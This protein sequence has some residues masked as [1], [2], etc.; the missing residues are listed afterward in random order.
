MYGIAQKI[1]ANPAKYSLQQLTDGV[2]SGVIP[3]YI[4]IP[5]IQE[6]IQ[7]EKEAQAM[8]M[9]QNQPPIAEQVL[10]ESSGIDKLPSGLPQSYAGGGIIAFANGGMFDEEDNED[11]DGDYEKEMSRAME[12]I[13]SLR[14]RVSNL[15][16]AQDAFNLEG[17]IEALMPALMATESKEGVSVKRGNEPSKSIERQSSSISQPSDLEKLIAL[18]QQKESGGRRNDREGNVL[19]SPKGAMGEMQ[20]MP[21]TAR[22]PG[23]GIT[24]A[25]AGDLDDLA[26]VGK[27]YFAK[28][29]QRYG[30][31]K[32]AAVAYNWGPGNTDKW[33]MAGADPSRLPD[34]T[35]NYIK[36]FD[37]G[38]IVGLAGGDLIIPPADDLEKQKDMLRRMR[39]IESARAAFNTLPAAEAATTAAAEAPKA[40]SGI[41]SLLGRLALPLG[42]A[43]TG[44]E[45]TKAYMDKKQKEELEK[46]GPEPELTEEEI[47]RASKPAFMG[48]VSMS[49]KVQKERGI[50]ALAPLSYTP[51]G[52]A[53]FGPHPGNKLPPKLAA[54]A[55]TTPAVV[56]T[57]EMQL[58]PLET[59][60]VGSEPVAAVEA[61]VEQSATSTPESDYMDELRRQIAEGRAAMKNQREID[62]Y[63]SLLSAGL[64]M[65][66]GTS[67]YAAANIGAGAMQG[68]GAYQRAAQ[69]RGAD[70]RG[71]LSAQLGL[72]K[73][74][75]YDAYKQEA[76]GLRKDIAEAERLRKT[77]AGKDAAA[78]KAAALTERQ[79]KTD[80]DI[81]TNMDRQAEKL[82]ESSGKLAALEN[83]GRPADEIARAK[84]RMID[85]LLM[86]NKRY[87]SIYNRLYPGITESFGESKIR[88][89]D[90]KTGQLK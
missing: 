50:K 20:V 13:E 87:Q 62:N 70:E 76:L 45:A 21:G 8:P 55:S 67:P 32:L 43:T 34:E 42:I 39:R 24:P 1:L 83:I 4:G 52:E 25:R 61:P 9:A 58:K 86:Q 89:Y 59:V 90:P 80:E 28:M 73:L 44:Y 56:P 5:L 46:Y 37:Q 48:D 51:A 68:I 23:F 19:T 17:G 12:M 29:M 75:G 22:D 74:A 81:L 30:D 18:V 11:E 15:K 66:G 64:G 69:L 36:G 65:L 71:L 78:A 26:R 27:E 7:D 16:G 60:Q 33:L 40:V 31:P 57:E 38:G 72:G 49:P 14:A 85:D 54:P 88:E 82:V 3:A 77:E 53:I 47:A 6:R 35:R 41:R 79:R 63:M 2:Q 84:K 10:A